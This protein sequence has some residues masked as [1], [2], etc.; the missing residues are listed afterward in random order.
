MT[1]KKNN[2]SCVIVK[3]FVS[4]ENFIDLKKFLKNLEN[5]LKIIYY[6]SMMCISHLLSFFFNNFLN[7][8]SEIDKSAG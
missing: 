6:S 1:N 2:F 5:K 7:Y 8:L 4:D 3:F